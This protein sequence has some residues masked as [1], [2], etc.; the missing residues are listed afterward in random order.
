MGKSN[1]VF[2][3]LGALLGV[4]GCKRRLVVNN[5]QCA[6]HNGIAQVGRPVLY[7]FSRVF[8]STGLKISRLQPS[9]RKQLGRTFESGKIAKF[10]KDNRCRSYT[11]SGN[12]QHGR[13]KTKDTIINLQL[14]F[15][16]LA[17]ELVVDV[18][19]DLHFLKQIVAG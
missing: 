8:R 19:R 11:D 6:V 17:L 13:S 1:A 12:G 15:L 7:H 3:A 9:K 18:N 4:V 16:H 2:L 5:G 14:D 10:R